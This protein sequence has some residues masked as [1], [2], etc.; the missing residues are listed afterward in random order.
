MVMPIVPKIEFNF[1]VDVIMHITIIVSQVQKAVWKFSVFMA[2]VERKNSSPE[3]FED[4]VYLD[5]PFWGHVNT[6]LYFSFL[7]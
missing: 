5:L 7:S 2:V 1:E 3:R 6:D 4:S